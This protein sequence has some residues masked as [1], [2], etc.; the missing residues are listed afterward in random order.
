MEMLGGVEG[1]KLAACSIQQL[2][3]MII[4]NGFTALLFASS[5]RQEYKK[6]MNHQLKMRQ[7]PARSSE[8]SGMYCRVIN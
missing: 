7:Y 8:S 5:A 6:D 4:R 3:I 1:H 2:H